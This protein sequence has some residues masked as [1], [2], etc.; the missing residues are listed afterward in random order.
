[1]G[2]FSQLPEMLGNPLLY[3]LPPGLP[4]PK[5]VNTRQSIRGK[6]D[7]ACLGSG[8]PLGGIALS[9]ASGFSFAFHLSSNFRD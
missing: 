3:K 1:M 7:G 8:E 4:I 2:I 5:P 6:G 9:A